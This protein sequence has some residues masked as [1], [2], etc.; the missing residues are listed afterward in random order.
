MN[1]PQRLNIFGGIIAAKLGEAPLF[2]HS[3]RH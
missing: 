2:E 1:A 3:R